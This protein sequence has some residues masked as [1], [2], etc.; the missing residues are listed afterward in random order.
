MQKPIVGEKL[1]FAT[2]ISSNEQ[3]SQSYSYI[4]QVKDENNKIVDLRW[5]DGKIDPAKKKTTEISWEPMISGKYTIEI[6]VW[7]G[8]NSGTPLA[9]K[10]EYHLDVR[11]T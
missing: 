5:V 3:K 9:K 11:S 7:D 10:T 8:I 1:V 6:F 4:I 2:E